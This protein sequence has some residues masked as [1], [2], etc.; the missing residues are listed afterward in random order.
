M[1]ALSDAGVDIERLADAVGHINSN[2]TKTTYRH[3]IADVVSET[4]T[5]MDRLYQP[6]GDK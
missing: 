2:V 3:Q 4:A 6:G 1:S 5:V